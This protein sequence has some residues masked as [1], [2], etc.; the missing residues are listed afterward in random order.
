[1]GALQFS[2]NESINVEFKSSLFFRLVHK[3]AE[4]SR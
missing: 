1:M 2:L 4:K 3:I